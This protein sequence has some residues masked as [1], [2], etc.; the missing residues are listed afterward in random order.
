MYNQIIYFLIVLFIFS[1]QDSPEKHFFLGWK[2]ALALLV[3]QFFLFY[4]LCKKFYSRALRKVA[5]AGI[6]PALVNYSTENILNILALVFTVF[7]VFGIQVTRFFYLIPFVSSSATLSA[8]VGLCLYFVYLGIIWHHAFRFQQSVSGEFFTSGRYIKQQLVLYVGLLLPWI[9][10]SGFS[11]ILEKVIPIHFLKTEEGQIFTFVVGIVL[12]ALFG[13]YLV[14]KVW[15][16][17]PIPR[18]D[19]RR[20]ILEDFCSENNFEVRELLFW[21]LFGGRTL[22]A[23][24]VGFI[25]R[26]RYILITP[27]LYGLLNGDE[28]R[29]VIAH[30]MGHVK[31]KHM[32]FYLAFFIGF[33]VLLYSFSDIVL[34]VLLGNGFF[35]RMAVS[36]GTL[37]QSLFAFFCS[38]PFLLLLVLYFRVVFGYFMRNCERQA[39][40]FALNTVGTPWPL[41]SSF[42]K[43]ALA[44]GNI[45]DVPSWHHYSIRQRIDFLKHAYLNPAVGEAHNRKLKKSIV[46]F[47][48]FIVFLGAGGKVVKNSNWYL[49]KNIDITVNIIAQDLNKPFFSPEVY[50]HYGAYLSQK[51]RF[52]LARIVL[53][54]GLKLYPDNP[55]ILNNLA[56][57]Y[58]T[59]PSP[60]KLP[61]RA[62]SLARKALKYA[63]ER[64]YI[65]DTL[66]EAY[67]V[68]GEY[69]K[70][71]SAIDRALDLEVNDYYLRQRRKIASSMKSRKEQYFQ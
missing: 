59:A 3:F 65:W 62:I 52:D 40:L 9:F 28:L 33:S 60:L 16:C 47:F 63:P 1:F 15:G 23:A 22:T 53:E 34:V 11:E 32:P 18:D 2:T 7:L 19:S 10:L 69:S 48:A 21:P 13:P 57:L 70:A 36:T 14:V 5:S 58:A 8:F 37:G 41:I 68:K 46:T 27:S 38:I 71:L 44:S 6:S 43:I 45:E 51:G 17:E 4:V 35:L 30:E 39:D 67:Y 12:F 56:W 29:A 25:S 54:R 24:I 61:D 49:E 31:L 55:D 66:A 42:Q 50:A 20:R 26:W 64:A